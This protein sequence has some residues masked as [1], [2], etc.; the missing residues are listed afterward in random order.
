MFDEELQYFKEHQETLVS[1]YRGKILVLKN[2]ELIGVYDN[3]TQAYFESQK[4]H[5]LG[6]FM[7]QPCEPGSDA[8]SV[9]IATHGLF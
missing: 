9:T 6:T 5:E 1:K 4:D 2:G 7:L 8:Y 3:L